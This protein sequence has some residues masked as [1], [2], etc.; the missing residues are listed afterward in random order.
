MIDIIIAFGVFAVVVGPCVIGMT[1]K[2]LGDKR[3]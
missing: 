2:R 1:I 3:A